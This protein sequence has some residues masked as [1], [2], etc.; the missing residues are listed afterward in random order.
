MSLTNPQ[1]R[2]LKALAQRLEPV[3][4]VGKAGVTDELLVSLE[5]ALSSHE[6]I[7]IK[8]TAFKEE[9]KS[10]AADIAARSRSELV[11]II[12]H[13]AVLYRE[14]ADPAKRKVLV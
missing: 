4:Y 13:V 7:K 2:K 5:Q 8:F 11:W 6:L 3:V 1:V 12:G 9:K 14:H 10:L